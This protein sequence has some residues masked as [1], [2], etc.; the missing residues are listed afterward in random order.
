MLEKLKNSEPAL[1]MLM[2][3]YQSLADE[4]PTSYDWGRINNT[5]ILL[6]PMEKATK[7]L[8]AARYPTW[9]LIRRVFL[10]LQVFLKRYVEDV[11][12]SECIMASSM[13]QKIEEYWTILD[14]LSMVSTVLDSRYKLVDFPEGEKT[15]SAINTIRMLIDSYLANDTSITLNLSTIHMTN[16]ETQENL[17]DFFATLSQSN[18]R[19]Q[20]TTNQRSNNELDRYLTDSASP[21]TDPL[22]WWHAH[23]LEFPILSKIARDYLAIQAT[24]VS[25]EQV[26]SVAGNTIT[27]RR[28]RLN[29]TITR[30]SLCLKSWMNKGVG[31]N[32]LEN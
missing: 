13:L 31:H 5:M 24:S 22:I 20:L 1:R 12:F 7:L 9:G 27:K 11:T 2:A 32:K 3:T 29:P 6:N 26:F 18:N 17:Q 8:S 28:N 16:N 14:D 19:I 15:I 4:F 23:A 10:G 21:E 25:C 30:A